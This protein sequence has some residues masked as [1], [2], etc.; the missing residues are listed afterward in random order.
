[1]KLLQT[2]SLVVGTVTTGLM[3][4][5]FFAYANSVMPALRLGDDRAFVSTMQEI[6]RVIQNGTFLLCFMGTLFILGAAAALH[7]SGDGRKVLPWIIAGLVL[8]VVM[9]AITFGINIPLN[10]QL[11]AAGDVGQIANLGA[12]RADFESK[13]VTW[14]AIRAVAN[15]A[16]FGCLAWALVVHGSQRLAANAAAPAPTTHAVLQPPAHR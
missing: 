13:W 1:M 2:L 12:V 4:G 9:L 5:V 14:N 11:D 8:Y 6:N 3:A 16:A 10:N 7:L 15:V